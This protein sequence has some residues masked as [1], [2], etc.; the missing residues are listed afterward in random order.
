VSALPSKK[1]MVCTQSNLVTTMGKN[2][3]AA[4]KQLSLAIDDLC[5]VYV[6]PLHIS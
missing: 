2:L 6:I 1:E 3:S 4:E 5:V